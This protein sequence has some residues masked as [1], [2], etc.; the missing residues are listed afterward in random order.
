MSY[1]IDL[2]DPITKEVIELD[3][4]HQMKGG[5]YVLGGTTQ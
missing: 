4:P 1:D 3:E 2:C 5:T